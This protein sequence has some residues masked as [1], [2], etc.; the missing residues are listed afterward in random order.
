[1]VH[2]C[3]D[4]KLVK[5]NIFTRFVRCSKAASTTLIVENQDILDIIHYNNELL[6]K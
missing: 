5:S 3:V 2:A 6:N 4:Q 1:M